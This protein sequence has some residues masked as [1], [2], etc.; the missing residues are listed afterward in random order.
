MKREK[1]PGVKASW[2]FQ[3]GVSD[4]SPIDVE[5]RSRSDTATP[6][7]HPSLDLG[8]HC[9]VSTGPALACRVTRA[10]DPGGSLPTPTQGSAYQQPHLGLDFLLCLNLY[11]PAQNNIQ[12]RSTHTP[13]ALNWGRKAKLSRGQ[14]LNG[15]RPLTPSNLL[16]PKHARRHPQIPQPPDH[17]MD[18]LT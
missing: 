7:R 5:C 12:R 6:L 10:L 8:T 9:P 2:S 18:I 13:I 14:H 1:K 15:H 17:N 11:F 4:Y 3:H 16:H